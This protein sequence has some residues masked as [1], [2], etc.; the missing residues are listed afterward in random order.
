ML[1][2]AALVVVVALGACV[3]SAGPV[4]A[5][6]GLEDAERVFIRTTDTGVT[7]RAFS[8]D[9]PDGA[10][11]AP[12]TGPGCPPPACQMQSAL[13]IGLSNEAA[14]SEGWAEL[15]RPG[16]DALR[17]VMASGFGS[18]FDAPAAWV[19]LQTGEGVARVRATFRDGRTDEMRP[20]D[21]LAVLASP[22]RGTPEDYSVPAG[23]AVALDKDGEVVGRVRFGPDER[24]DSPPAHCIV[25]LDGEFP[26]PTGTPPADAVSA[27][28][29]VRAA[30]TAAYTPGGTESLAF[31]EDGATLTDVVLAGAERYPQYRGKISA[32][33][34]EVR[35]VDD[36]EAAVRFFLLVD[37]QPLAPAGVGRVK[38]ID[39]Q[40]LLT[41]DT[42]CRMLQLGGLYCPAPEKDV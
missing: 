24:L 16:D 7:I 38:L 19:A 41:R 31:I 34:E 33:I 27:E 3:V 17:T 28:A 30:V 21:N 14:V 37:G 23:R 11:P 12:C 22:V 26:K 40:W 42:F 39:G 4:Q 25:G 6:G 15:Y 13:V 10:Y 18:T 9:Y 20:R 8:G 2:R 35:F 5:K 29:A 32:S 1:G 36:S